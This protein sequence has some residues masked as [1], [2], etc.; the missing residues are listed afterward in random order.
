MAGCLDS[1]D[2]RQRTVLELR[3]GLDGERPHTLE[4]IADVFDVTRERVR[5]I[6]TQSLAK[7]AALAEAQQ[8]RG[9]ALP[10]A[11]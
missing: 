9:M 6:E 4:E 8:L 2:D 3:Y 1:L 5:Q 7:L 11:V 10:Q